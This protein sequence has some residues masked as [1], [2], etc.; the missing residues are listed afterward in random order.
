MTTLLGN[1]IPKPAL[2]NWAG[3]PPPNTR[4]TTGRT[5]GAVAVGAPQR[6]KEVAVQGA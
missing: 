6:A 3:T 5:V 4:S 1:G 2:I